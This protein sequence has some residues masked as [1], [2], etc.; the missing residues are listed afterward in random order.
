MAERPL[1]I[2]PSAENIGPPAGPR[3]GSKPFVPTRETQAG[4]IGPS[5]RRLREALNRGPDHVLELRDDPTAL[6]PDRVIVFE[7]AG[8]VADFA[9]AAARIPGLE[10]M[11]EYE[12]EAEP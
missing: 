6:A 10:M 8:T 11:I 7:I 5:F 9:K 12:T 3:G 2:L 4:R 1:L